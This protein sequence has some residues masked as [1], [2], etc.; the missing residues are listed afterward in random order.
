MRTHLRN[1]LTEAHYKAIASAVAEVQNGT[2]EAPEKMLRESLAWRQHT[3][4]SWRSS[5]PRQRG[6]FSFPDVAGSLLVECA[7]YRRV[8][9]LCNFSK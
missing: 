8:L 7:A 6:Y 4:A 1:H 9:K 2:H 5:K 3:L